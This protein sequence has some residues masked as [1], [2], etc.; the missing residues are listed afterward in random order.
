M[1]YSNDYQQMSSVEK[2]RLCDGGTMNETLN[3]I[4]K[5][6]PQQNYQQNNFS[7]TKRPSS[8]NDFDDHRN[9]PKQQRVHPNNGNDKMQSQQQ[10]PKLLPRRLNDQQNNSSL[11]HQASPTLTTNS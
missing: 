6:H 8:S 9:S 1:S 3:R 10:R 4:A 7:C 11:Q 5:Q 2:D